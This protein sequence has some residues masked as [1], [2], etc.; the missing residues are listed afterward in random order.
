MMD[1]L[2]VRGAIIGLVF[3]AIG[4]AAH[5]IWKLMRSPSE[6]ARRARI[7]LYLLIGLPIA[8]VIVHDLGVVAAL[9]IAALIGAGIWIKRGFKQ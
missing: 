6:G 7:V 3:A 9:V 8:A 1:E 2:L 4:F 5:Y